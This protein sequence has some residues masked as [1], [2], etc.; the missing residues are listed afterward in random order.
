VIK[1]IHLTNILQVEKMTRTQARNGAAV[2]NA[3]ALV[4]YGKSP[5]FYGMF[6]I[7]E[8]AKVSGMSKPTVTK[9]IEMLKDH[10]LVIEH[11]RD[12]RYCTKLTPRT[13]RYTGKGF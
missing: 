9:Y 1:F 3:I 5:I 13:F 8:V 11:E 4:A 10:E 12:M 6:T 2:E 7:G